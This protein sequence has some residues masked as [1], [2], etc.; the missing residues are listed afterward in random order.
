MARFHCYVEYR[1]HHLGIYQTWNE[2]KAQ[3]LGCPNAEFKGF[4]NME[5]ARVSCLNCHGQFE[6]PWTGK[7]KT[8]ICKCAHPDDKWQVGVNFSSSRDPALD[9][10]RPSCFH[11]LFKLLCYLPCYGGLSLECPLLMCFCLVFCMNAMMQG[12]TLSLQLSARDGYNVYIL[13]G[14]PLPISN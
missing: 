11:M 9:H 8:R 4:N 3:V 12:Y 6:L 1:G 2:C 7:T 10:Y 14:S 13:Y 5:E